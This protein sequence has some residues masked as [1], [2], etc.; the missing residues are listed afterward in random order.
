TPS[1]AHLPPRYLKTFASGTPK[2]AAFG[3]HESMD[4]KT[5]L[6]A[7]PV[8]CPEITYGLYCSFGVCRSRYRWTNGAQLT[9][10][11]FLASV[12]H[13]A[14]KVNGVPAIVTPEITE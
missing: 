12:Q 13:T 7:S 11:F 5:M 10:R 9:R 6:G 14:R 1:G 3:A 2:R 4:F 8:A